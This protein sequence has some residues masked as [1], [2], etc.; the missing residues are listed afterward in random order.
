MADKVI[1][2]NIMTALV[3]NTK[4]ID[5]NTQLITKLTAEKDKKDTNEKN[6][7]SVNKVEAN[8][9][10]DERKRYANIGKELFK[11]LLSSLENI[12]KREKKKKEMLIQDDASTINKAVKTQYNKKGSPEKEKSSWLSTLL[13]ILGAIRRRCILF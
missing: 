9:T 6:I 1:P 12:L 3:E 10:G 2:D 7:V 8:L 5:A 11:P 4:T 13:L